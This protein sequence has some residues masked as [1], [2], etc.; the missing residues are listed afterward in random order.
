MDAL[1]HFLDPIAAD[2]DY[3]WFLAGV[4]WLGL[5]VLAF[6]SRSGRLPRVSG[7]LVTAAVA[8][9]AHAVA[10][11]HLMVA[12]RDIF[13][14][15]RW[16][17]D[18]LLAVPL[19]LGVGAL[20][21]A[22]WKTTGRWIAATI[23][24]G[25]VAARVSVPDWSAHLIALVACF[26]GWR[27]TAGR[28]Q[29]PE[30]FRPWG[31]RA[32]ALL[33]AFPLVSPAGPIALWIGESQQWNRL[34]RLGLPSAMLCFATAL[35]WLWVFLRPEAKSHDSDEAALTHRR[36][37]QRFGGALGAWL[38]LGF[39][40]T[41]FSGQ[42]ARATFERSLLSQARIGAAIVDTRALRECLTPAFHLSPPITVTD[43]AGSPGSYALSDH[44]TAPRLAGLRATLSIVRKAA[45][46]GD[47]AHL[48]THRDGWLVSIAFDER[49]PVNPGEVPL[50]HRLT[51]QDF[52][53]WADRKEYVAGPISQ[54][55]MHMSARAPL[56]DSAG[57]MLGWLAIDVPVDLWIT[58]QTQARA[59]SLLLTGAGVVL[60]LLIF[61]LR[62]R[63]RERLSAQ[64]AAAEAL[65]AEQRQ[66]VFL[67]KVSHELRTPIQN[68]LG[69]AQ[70]VQ[71]A[72]G[73]LL[74]QERLEAVRAQGALLIRLVNDLIDLS[75]AHAGEFRLQ[76]RPCH[77]FPCMA[78]AIES[79]RPKAEAKS[80]ALHVEF[81]RPDAG[82]VRC[83]PERLRQ[84]VTNLVG[85]AIKFTRTGWVRVQ[86]RTLETVGQPPRCE[87]LVADSGPGISAE[88]QLLLFKP[89]ERL[90]ADGQT[91]GSGLGL[92]L[93]QKICREMGGSLDVESDGATGTIFKATFAIPAA[94][95]AAVAAAVFTHPATTP[96]RVLV[97][98]DNMLV[99]RLFRAWLES[100]QAMVSEATDGLE[101]HRQVLASTP[102]VLLV[103]ISMP[104]LDGI[105]LTRRLRH[106]GFLSDRLRI[107]GVSAHAAEADRLAALAAG[108]NVLLQ[109]P[110]E[111]ADLVAAILTTPSPENGN[112][113]PPVPLPGSLRTEFQ[114]MAPHLVADLDAAS[115]SSDWDR[116]ARVA[117]DLG[118]CAFALQ[119]RELAQAS[120]LLEQ[121]GRTR[122]PVPDGLVARIQVAV[123]HLVG[124]SLSVGT[125]PAEVKTPSHPPSHHHEFVPIQRRHH[126][127]PPGRN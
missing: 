116:L 94:A 29:I 69:Y 102:D 65:R 101:A 16:Q 99:R 105:S 68:I 34:P 126:A 106:E 125:P 13:G 70:L 60:G 15:A 21:W 38:V 23:L 123:A 81:S 92:A 67:A 31:R 107:V 33:V 27:L 43:S 93:C 100:A 104:G 6:F 111:Q 35:V 37:L 1:L 90:A 98:D 9:M 89:F 113:R 119:D 8:A 55:G 52:L 53:A 124:P 78:E 32:V 26:A 75:A 77:L 118:N 22:A 66:T 49:V 44:L 74:G 18:L 51:A 7:W 83:D 115:R 121:L 3:F 48:L 112:P 110:L 40:L 12:R 63:S 86:V 71:P 91:E 28:A 24:V 19:A 57:H 127:P 50:H 96:L 73:D 120:A 64:Q 95:G 62:I 97:V 87:L 59:Q 61:G 42:L 56:K 11:A 109:K 108:M 76:A 54:W 45:D 4:A 58:A 17:D 122:H 30:T 85:N 39:G 5:I 84:V 10:S 41:G 47:W 114:S 36:E 117:H 46:H 14:V 80:L 103:D 79:L 25:A 20:G 72:P 88:N 2:Q 82:I